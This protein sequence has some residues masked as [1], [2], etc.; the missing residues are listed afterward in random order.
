MMRAFVYLFGWA[1][2]FFLDFEAA[3]Q[4]TLYSF[5]SFLCLAWIQG[6]VGKVTTSLLLLF[7]WM[8]SQLCNGGNAVA[9]GFSFI[10]LSSLWSLIKY[11][12]SIYA[13]SP[14]F[15]FFG[16]TSPLKVVSGPLS[17]C[18]EDPMGN[19]RNSANRD[20]V[21]GVENF[22]LFLIYKVFYVTMAFELF[23]VLPLQGESSTGIFVFFISAVVFI[24]IY[25][26]LKSYFFLID[27]ITLIAGLPLY[28]KSF[29]RIFSVFTPAQ[30]WE[31]WNSS[32]YKF[33]R[34]IVLYPV[35]FRF[36]RNPNVGIALAF[37]LVFMFTTL[38]HGPTGNII[39][40][41]AL[42]FF[43]IVAFRY[44]VGDGS[45]ECFV[46]KALCWVVLWVIILN[47]D[48]FFVAG[49]LGEGLEL[50]AQ[51]WLGFLQVVRLDWRGVLQVD[52]GGFGSKTNFFSM[53][54]LVL[55]LPLF[56]IAQEKLGRH[57]L[58]RQILISVGFTLMLFFYDL[59]GVTIFHYAGF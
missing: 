41:F 20:I 16:L 51:W 42:H 57:S 13:Q 24:F 6:S 12:A 38:W 45:A 58:G 7:P 2:L 21:G 29:N 44:F 59:S 36:R 31:N 15:A 46:S 5:W 23:K 25:S 10:L 3:I 47:L 48:L 50:V 14:G 43:A 4:V 17:P 34:D 26:D 49:D 9:F 32:F 1:V 27:S 28:P 37:F 8:I 39:C 55:S 56:D 30:Y 19:P 22:L 33:F 52:A 54:L 11:E 40:F 53:Y 35:T 18:F